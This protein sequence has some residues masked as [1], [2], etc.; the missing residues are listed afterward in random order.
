MEISIPS[1]YV[2]LF[3]S[4]LQFGIPWRQQSQPNFECSALHSSLYMLTWMAS[5]LNLLLPQILLWELVLRLS[6]SLWRCILPK[7]SS[8]LFAFQPTSLRLSY[9]SQRKAFLGSNNHRIFWRH[10]ISNLALTHRNSA[11]WSWICQTLLNL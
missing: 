9:R 7:S 3:Y 1:H 6:L 11:V 5:F 8:V 4:I 2:V 10:R